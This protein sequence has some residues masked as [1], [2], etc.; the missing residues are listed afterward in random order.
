MV[1][2]SNAQQELLDKIIAIEKHS[3]TI[4]Q[5]LKELSNKGEFYFTYSTN[6]IPAD[7]KVFLISKKQTVKSYLDYMFT[8]CGID[9]VV[10]N[11]K[12]ILKPKNNALKT[13][14]LKGVVKDKSCND[15]IS[16]VNVKVAGT[17]HGTTT[18]DAGHF[19]LL[20][21]IHAQSQKIELQFSHVSYKNLEIAWKKTEKNIEVFLETNI[22]NIPE[23]NIFGVPQI[24]FADVEYQIYD[25]EIFHENILLVVYE[26]RLSKSKLLLVDKD[27]KAIC[28]KDISG[29]PVGMYK[30]CIGDINLITFYYPFKITL[31]SGCLSVSHAKQNWQNKINKPCVTQSKNGLFFYYYYGPARLSVD[32]S[33]FNPITKN[34]SV[35][36][37]VKDTIAMNE[38]KD[39]LEK[40][41]AQPVSRGSM[42]DI[43][44]GE[45]EGD[46]KETFSQQTL[47]NRK[48]TVYAP[49]LAFRDSLY[50]FNHCD[51]KIEVYSMNARLKR[52]INIKYHKNDGWKYKIFLDKATNSVYTCFFR[53]NIYEFFEIDLQT[54]ELK[55]P[56]KIYNNWIDKVQIHAGNIYYIYKPAQYNFKKC[57]YK[58]KL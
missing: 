11:N 31:N 40:N 16:N 33:F 32:Y 36:R 9:Y 17:P 13:I 1:L 37:Q 57:L 56:C 27:Q 8:D 43:K 7:K 6:H 47:E 50:I 51:N 26:K 5:L 4:E 20:V 49:M 38:L 35:F 30:D 14:V 2:S 12:V 19:S 52:S 58:Q 39:K 44:V 34:D 24:A 53:N 10:L 28:M 23:I 22:V 25:Y 41:D 29:T 21:P 45:W 48:K 3:Y 55:N 15:G 18:N 46:D 54:G 42:A